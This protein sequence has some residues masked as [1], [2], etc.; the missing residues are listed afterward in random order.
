MNAN[1][2]DLVKASQKLL[3]VVCKSNGAISIYRRE[4]LLIH[5]SKPLVEIFG[6]PWLGSITGQDIGIVEHVEDMSNM[7][8]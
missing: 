8:S 7:L 4:G 2:G 5:D 6:I 3:I 1:C